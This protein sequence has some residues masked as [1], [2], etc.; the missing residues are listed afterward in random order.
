MI[1]E[2]KEPIEAEWPRWACI[3]DPAFARG[4]NIVA[5]TIIHLGVA[6]AFGMEW[7]PTDSFL[8]EPTRV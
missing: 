1:M 3:D 2:M 4:L 8:T 6:E 7:S 5:G